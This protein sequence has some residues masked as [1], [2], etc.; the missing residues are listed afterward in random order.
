MTEVAKKKMIYFIK[1]NFHEKSSREKGPANK[2][3][4]DNFFIFLLEKSNEK[5]D[6]SQQNTNTSIF[7]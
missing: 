7:H 2:F 5:H 3:A 6:L 1:I 4:P